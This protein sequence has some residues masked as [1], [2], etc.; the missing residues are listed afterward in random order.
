MKSGDLKLNINFPANLIPT[1]ESTK[2]NKFIE[3]T[4]FAQ[5]KEY[6]FKF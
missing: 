2:N 5:D 6:I 4:E 1:N 3:E